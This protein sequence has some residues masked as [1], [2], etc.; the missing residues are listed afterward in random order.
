[1]TIH[2]VIARTLT[3][4]AST[5]VALPFVSCQNEVPTVG[6]NL[7]GGEVQIALDS[8]IWNG[9]QQYI[10]RGEDSTLITCPKIQF[11]TEYEKAVDSRSTT[12]LLGRL[13]VPEYGDLRCSFVS[14][15]MS[16]TNLNIPD[17]IGINQ[18]DSMKLVLSVPRG[19]LTGDSLAPSS[20]E[21]SS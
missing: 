12:N 6:S 13:S 20:S 15:L 10:Y 14:Q 18:I 21:P 9:E 16:V 7:A 4:A 2:K 17:T 8:L 1:M 11:A 5:I 3:L 19:Q